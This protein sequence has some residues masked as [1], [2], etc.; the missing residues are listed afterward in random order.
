MKTIKSFGEYPKY[1]LHDA[2]V[3]KIEYADDNLIFTFNYIFPMR[4]V[5]NRLIRLRLYLRNVMLMI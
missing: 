2:R 5:M 1:S 3:Q 4:T